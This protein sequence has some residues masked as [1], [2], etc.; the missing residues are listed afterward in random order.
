MATS[1]SVN[2]TA[3]S[4]L[5]DGKSSGDLLSPNAVSLD[6]NNRFFLLRKDSERRETLV[7]I[8][9][10]FKKEVR[11]HKVWVETGSAGSNGVLSDRPVVASLDQP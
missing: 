8:M 3:A 4:T 6:P 11:K 1:L 2:N 9:N 10:E 7:T 5:S